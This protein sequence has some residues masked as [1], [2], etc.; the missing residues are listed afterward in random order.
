[1][2][3]EQRGQTSGARRRG[4]LYAEDNQAIPQGSIQAAAQEGHEIARDRQ[5]EPRAHLALPPSV[6]RR[7]AAV[8][9]VE[10]LEEL[11]QFFLVDALSRVGYL[12]PGAA[13]LWA[14]ATLDFD[15]AAVGRELAGR[16]DRREWLEPGIQH[17]KMSRVFLGDS[18]WRNQWI[19]SGWNG[20]QQARGRPAGTAIDENQVRWN[21]TSLITPISH[22]QVSVLQQQNR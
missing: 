20:S 2:R 22:D 8:A 14:R 12:N 9:P 17:Q 21:G 3:Y 1:M 19:L 6:Q 13:R 11:R 18:S 16:I 4:Q 10:P 15:P 5:T 7:A